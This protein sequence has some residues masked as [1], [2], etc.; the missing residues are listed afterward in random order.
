MTHY[1][2]WL[3]PD[4]LLDTLQHRVYICTAVCVGALA[5]TGKNGN[6]VAVS[7]VGNPECTGPQLNDGRISKQTGARTHDT[8]KQRS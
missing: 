4:T 3:V 7:V 5:Y 1:G 2:G 8:R 6:R